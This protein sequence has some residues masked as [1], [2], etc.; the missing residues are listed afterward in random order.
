MLPPDLITEARI[1]SGCEVTSK[2]RLL[3]SLGELLAEAADRPE[4]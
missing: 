4:P 1:L 2:K 3:E